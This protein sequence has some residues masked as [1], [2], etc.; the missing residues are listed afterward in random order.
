MALHLA[1]T[2]GNEV[3]VRLLLD[4]GASVDTTEYA[5]DTALHTDVEIDD[6]AIIRLLLTNVANPDIGDGDRDTSLIVAAR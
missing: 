2:C 1:A 5:G 6:D 4:K 3:A